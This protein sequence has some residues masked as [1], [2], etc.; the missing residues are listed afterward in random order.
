MLRNQW[1]STKHR[2]TKHGREESLGQATSGIQGESVN[3]WSSMGLRHNGAAAKAANISPLFPASLRLMIKSKTCGKALSIWWV[4]FVKRLSL[5]FAPCETARCTNVLE[6]SAGKT[7]SSSPCSASRGTS[8]R[9]R[10]GND[11]GTNSG[12][13]FMRCL[14][15]T[16]LYEQCKIMSLWFK[17][18]LLWKVLWTFFKQLETN[19]N[20]EAATHA[21]G[22]TRK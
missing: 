7:L 3:R 21:G 20:A 13:M 17:W 6:H 22:T 15:N 1:G 5:A 4:S 12:R 14:W 9:E 18:W 10:F 19:F 16:N 2:S 11:L 8:K